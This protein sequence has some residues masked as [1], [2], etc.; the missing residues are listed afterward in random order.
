[1]DSNKLEHLMKLALQ[2]SGLSPNIGA[3]IEKDI[4][5]ASDR[6]VFRFED[7]LTIMSGRINLEDSRRVRMAKLE[8]WV[9]QV[10]GE[11]DKRVSEMMAKYYTVA[12]ETQQPNGWD[13]YIG[14]AGAPLK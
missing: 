8:D 1:M 13:G 5:Q 11:V 10:K 9:E 7:S 14:D 3:T 2:G 6:A 4:S 12:A